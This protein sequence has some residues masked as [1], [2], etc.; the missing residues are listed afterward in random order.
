MLTEAVLSR[1][2][3]TLD[4]SSHVGSRIGDASPVRSKLAVSSQS[5]SRVSGSAHPGSRLGGR[6]HFGSWLGGPVGPSPIKKEV[7]K[8]AGTHV[9]AYFCVPLIF[10][11]VF[12]KCKFIHWMT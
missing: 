11:P 4:D 12:S 1:D 5:G 2:S 9:Q 7:L 3:G 8:I 6:S 10:V